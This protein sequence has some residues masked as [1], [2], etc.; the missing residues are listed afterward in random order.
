MTLLLEGLVRGA[1][2]L[3]RGILLRVERIEHLVERPAHDR[4]AALGDRVVEDRDVLLDRL[5]DDRVRSRG[6][7]LGELRQHVVALVE[8]RSVD[9][10]AAE[11]ADQ[12]AADRRR[13]ALTTTF[14]DMWFLDSG[15][16]GAPLI[17][18]A[19]PQPCPVRV[20]CE[21]GGV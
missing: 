7:R 12:R 5:G 18:A 3:L 16:D 19:G 2:G 4:S 21:R 1:R 20:L 14:S 13:A 9:E 6:N 11:R 15:S 8:A 17:G 10:R